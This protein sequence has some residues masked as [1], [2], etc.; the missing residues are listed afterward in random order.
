MKMEMEACEFEKGCRYK[1]MKPYNSCT[2]RSTAQPIPLGCV[3]VWR[4]IVELSLVTNSEFPKILTE[5][6]L[7]VLRAIF[8]S[9]SFECGISYIIC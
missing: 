1:R 6:L 9:D 7:A 5:E 2:H 8:G 4:K 3:G